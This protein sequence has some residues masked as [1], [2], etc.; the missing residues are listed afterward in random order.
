MVSI[1]WKLARTLLPKR[2]LKLLR[3]LVNLASMPEERLDVIENNIQNLLHLNYN[4]IAKELDQRTIFRTREFKAYSQ[5]GEDGLLLYIFSKIGTTNCCF[6][7]IGIGDGRECNTANL[8]IN[9]GWHGLLI[10]GEE[11][12]VAK[13]KHYYENK[14]EIKAS[15]IKVIQCFVT[16]ENINKVLSDNG[17]E[18][19][20]DLLSIDIN[21]N[22][23]WI[24]KAITAIEPRAVV[25]E[26]NASLGYDRS[27]TVKYDPN[28]YRHE[29]HPS[30]WYHGASLTA[31]TKLGNSKGYI[32]V[33][34]ECSGVNAFFIRKEIAQ[35]KLFAVSPQEA[36]YAN[37]RRS[38]IESTLEQFERIK[39]L[40]FDHV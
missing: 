25:I 4:S 10:D 20:I 13:A 14:P 35:G 18:G 8:S 34:C 17:C 36:Y 23:Y 16:T 9:F 32:L 39:H 29:K 28:F 2:Y 37:T 24:W 22:D 7:E 11:E 26:Y 30:G 12:N 1:L 27:L 6:V 21:G 33:G 38:K 3:N 40:D 31:L 19:E 15:Q 5:N